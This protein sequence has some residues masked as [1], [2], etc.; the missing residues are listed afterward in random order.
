MNAGP[1]NASSDFAERLESVRKIVFSVA[2]AYCR[3]PADLD[4]LV[5]EIV[6]ALWRTYGRYDGR[7]AFSTW[8]YRVAFNVAISFE[9]ARRRRS[10]VEP[11]E[12]ATLEAMS[13]A[14][15]ARERDER[16]D[17]VRSFV[18]TLP[19][20]DRALMLLYLD[21]YPYADI[22]DVLGISPSNVAT[23][24]NR[25]KDRL[26]REAAAQPAL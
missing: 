20:L 21:D 25:I 4:D 13:G 15:P 8:A 7:A 14:T 2:H 22:A 11:V 3:N 26:K 24:I 9:R 6:A 17:F 12:T 19:P 16:L 23:K 18:D 10:R 5:A 1:S